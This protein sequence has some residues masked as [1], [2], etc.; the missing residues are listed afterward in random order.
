VIIRGVGYRGRGAPDAAPRRLASILGATAV[1]LVTL[2]GQADALTTVGGYGRWPLRRLGYSER[3]A[4]IPHRER[5]QWHFR[6]RV[7]AGARHGSTSWY[8]LHLDVELTLAPSTRQGAV[9][10]SGLVNGFAACQINYTVTRARGAVR[11]ATNQFDL[12][13]GVKRS[14]TFGRLVE[15]QQTNYLQRRAVRAGTNDLAIQ[16]QQYGHARVQQIRILPHTAILVSPLAPAKLHLQ[17]ATSSQTINPGSEFTVKTTL[18]ARGGRP[19]KQV[20]LRAIY[21]HHLIRLVSSPRSIGQLV[22][23][24]YEALRFRALRQG[25]STIFVG[26]TSSANNQPVAPIWVRIDPRTGSS[27][28]IWRHLPFGLVLLPAILVLVIPRRRPVPT[29]G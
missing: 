21:D 9:Q 23:T 24:A 25:H 11:V 12:V 3:I 5:P 1:I 22:A 15:G 29:Q 13:D 27:S 6:F 4:A 2:A 20:R 7:P 26:A 17:V 10:A 16:V 14:T 8:L 19:A 28:W 18:S